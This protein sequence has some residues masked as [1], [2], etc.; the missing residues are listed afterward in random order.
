VQKSVLELLEHMLRRPAMYVPQLDVAN[1]QSFLI[2]LEAGCRLSGL[3]ITREI[4]Q[5]AAATRGWKWR[6]K[7]NVWHMRKKNL[8]DEEI[9]QELIAVEM[10][11]V[12]RGLGINA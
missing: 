6:A 10:E 5:E 9:I 3:D 1:V 11:A 7:R 4:Y 8:S 12:R 2:G